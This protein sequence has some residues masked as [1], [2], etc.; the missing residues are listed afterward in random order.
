MPDPTTVTPE[1]ELSQRRQLVYA[2]LLRYA[3]EAAPLRERIFDRLIM[4]AL[5][6]SDEKNAYRIGAIQSNLVLGA[7]MPRNFRVERI[8][9]SLERLQGNGKV[10][11]TEVRQRHAYYLS[12]KGQGELK[13]AISSAGDILQPV[14]KKLLANTDHALSYEAG[15][16]IVQAFIFECFARF[17]AQMAK[18]VTGQL[19]ASDLLR[20]ADAAAAFDAA[21]SGA[22]LCG[23]ARESLQARCVEFL[24]SGDSD[25]LN[26]KF[27]LAQGYYFAQL[28][29]LQDGGFSPLA[30][31]AFEESSFYLDTNVLLYG[32]L[33]DKADRAVFA[34]L[35][36]LAKRLNIRLVVTQATIKETLSLPDN[37]SKEL[38]RV[39]KVLPGELVC[40]VKDQLT[41][42]FLR[43]REEDPAMSLDAFLADIRAVQ[44][45]V[46]TRWGISILEE[47][48]DQILV[49]EVPAGIAT[50]I[51]EEAVKSRG[52]EKP[53]AALRHDVAHFFLVQ[54]ERSGNPKSWFLTRDRGLGVAATLL[55]GRG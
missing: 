28:V 54:R 55:A 51:Q 40:R 3:P 9:E 45:V 50:V 34:E 46:R 22:G 42:S 30:E 48:E 27:C 21:V 1:D 20:S 18:T 26:L 32:L 49:G 47:A 13:S 36:T 2:S 35:L 37:F 25:D 16:R 24:K 29:G 33:P 14:L 4:A 53:D 6:G 23:E 11:V 12:S 31:Q 41:E 5:L 43:A 15:S 44:E 39:M 10:H 17:G 52:W 8:Q 7:N 19:E 38:S